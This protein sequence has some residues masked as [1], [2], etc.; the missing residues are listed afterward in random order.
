M[1]SRE[2]LGT[3]RLSRVQNSAPVNILN[4]NDSG[5]VSGEGADECSLAETPC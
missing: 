4:M 3:P 2:S 5:M 1:S